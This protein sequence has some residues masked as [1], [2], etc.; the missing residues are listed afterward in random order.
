MVWLRIV[1]CIFVFGEN[2]VL[3]HLAPHESTAWETVFMGLVILMAIWV[4]E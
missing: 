3:I 1:A 2:L 4:K